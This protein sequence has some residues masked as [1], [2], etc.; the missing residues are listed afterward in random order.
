MDRRASVKLLSALQDSFRQHLNR[1]H[2]SAAS[3]DRRS[4]DCHFQTILENPLFSVK[5]KRR[6]VHRLGIESTDQLGHVLKRPV[7]YIKDEIAAGTAT[8]AMAQTCLSA[9]LLKANASQSHGQ[10]EPARSSGA[11]SVIVHWL[12]SS[13]VAEAEFLMQHP[14]Y[15]QLLMRFLNA[16]G[17]EH[18][19]WHWMKRLQKTIDENKTATNLFNIPGAQAMILRC[20]LRAEVK[21][22][23]GLNSAMDVF[24]RGVKGIP[25]WSGLSSIDVVAILKRGGRCLMYQI[26]ECRDLTSLNTE[27]LHSLIQTGDIWSTSPQLHQ[28]LLGLYHPKPI[29]IDVT[30]RFALDLLDKIDHHEIAKSKRSHRLDMVSLSLRLTKLLLSKGSETEAARVMRFLETHFPGEIGYSPPDPSLKSHQVKWQQR[31]QQFEET[32][33]RILD[34]FA[35]H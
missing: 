21:H 18:L 19:V 27:L 16:E 4:V 7:E 29:N 10:R 6:K 5:P 32:N 33:L 23:A 34:V 3:E 26:I 35:I 28:A 8:V 17:L 24:L 11:G 25:T 15:L 14:Y 31:K 9:Q 1:E 30:L 12:W 2:P 22:G 20:F 13:P